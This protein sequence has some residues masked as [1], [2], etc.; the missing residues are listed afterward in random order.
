MRSDSRLVRAIVVVIVIMISLGLVL[1][2]FSF[3]V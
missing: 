1:S 2:T 3:P